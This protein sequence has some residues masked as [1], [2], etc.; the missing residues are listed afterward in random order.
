MNIELSEPDNI[1]D[2]LLDG[3]GVG[4]PSCYT[5]YKNIRPLECL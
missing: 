5:C 1:S 4:I 2:I 3:F